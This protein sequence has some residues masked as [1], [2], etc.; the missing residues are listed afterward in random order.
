MTHAPVNKSWS[1]DSLE[2][3]Y[4]RLP[5]LL[6]FIEAI[7]MVSLT[8]S[9]VDALFSFQ[10]IS[11]G[12][13]SLRAL[14]A[15]VWPSVV[16]ALI[17]QICVRFAL[18]KIAASL[19]ATVRNLRI[20]LSATARS[21]CLGENYTLRQWLALVSIVL[22]ASLAAYTFNAGAAGPQGG[23][24]TSTTVLGLCFT[25]GSVCASTCKNVLEEVYMQK[26]NVD[27][28]QMVGA[29]GILLAGFAVT[30]LF[31]ADATG[32][33]PFTQTVWMVRSSS[34]LRWNLLFFF[35]AS[36]FGIRI[37][38]MIVAKYDSCTKM[39]VSAL[40]MC[41]TL[42]AELA[43]GHLTYGRRGIVLHLPFSLLC[44][45]GIFLTAA[46][47]A[48]YTSL[49]GAAE[50]PEIEPNEKTH[51]FAVPPPPHPCYNK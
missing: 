3:K 48:H 51:F 35:I 49:P 9:E 4:A 45:T 19:F 34:V 42:G 13:P 30:L 8:F 29:Q 6:L 24:W 32:I 10:E 16:C 43:L 11:C 20:P 1:Q 2:A 27:P 7:A 14:V 37:C 40:A 41:G 44:V 39:L 28:I 31:V 33:E 46:S 5:C 47:T 38:V 26:R 23:N 50:K 21:C 12:L 36:V 15:V 18:V 17:D 22:C 25:I